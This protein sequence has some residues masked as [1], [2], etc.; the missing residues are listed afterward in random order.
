MSS[1]IR[2][3]ALSLLTRREHSKYELQH[4]LCRKGFAAAAVAV[5]IQELSNQGLQ[6]D[7][8]FIEGY[9][10]MRVRR[11]FGLMRIQAELHERGIE[12]EQVES[13]L[14]ASDLSWLELA[15][16][17]RYKKF[18]KRVPQDLRERAQQMRYLYYKGFA[19]DHIKETFAC[20]TASDE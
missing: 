16:V 20:L 17:A 13:F 10:N 4:K 15:K 18:G 5:L 11:G 7:S 1:K 8:R 12:K 9:V 14:R 2:S 3:Y 6:S 19:S